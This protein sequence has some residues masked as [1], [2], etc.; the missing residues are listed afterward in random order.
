MDTGP[1]LDRC[2]DASD[3]RAMA[4]AIIIHSSGEIS[5]CC[6]VSGKVGVVSIHTCVSNCDK[7]SMAGP[8]TCIGGAEFASGKWCR[9]ATG[10]I[11]GS[12]IMRRIGNGAGCWHT[13]LASIP[14]SC[15]T[16]I[17]I[18]VGRGFAASLLR[19]G[20]SIGAININY[21]PSGKTATAAT[22]TC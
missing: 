20:Q 12:L 17:D 3:M 21:R 4:M 14:P 6:D 19:I 18:T 13:Q 22:A 2:H 5:A 9:T 10:K 16:I 8:T 1:I 7:A 11:L 15:P